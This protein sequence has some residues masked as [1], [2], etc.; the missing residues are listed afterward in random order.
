MTESK[1][2]QNKDV[3]HSIKIGDLI[4]VE[5]Y[6]FRIKGLTLEYNETPYVEIAS[7]GEEILDGSFKMDQDLEICD[8]SFKIDQI[9]E[10]IDQVLENM[11]PVNQD[12]PDS[13]NRSDDTVVL[14]LI[15]P[16]EEYALARNSGWQ[17]HQILHWCKNDLEP[18]AP[19]GF[20]R[21]L[22]NYNR[23]TYAK[24]Y[25]TPKA[26]EHINKMV[27]DAETHSFESPVIPPGPPHD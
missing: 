6:V 8:G 25:C 26:V 22:G 21:L 18:G 14:L 11:E 23:A 3:I 12:F 15:G 17:P 19:R 2:D 16:C 24:V 9:L 10:N 27:R 5:D 13:E 1:S 20:G 4:A 7:I